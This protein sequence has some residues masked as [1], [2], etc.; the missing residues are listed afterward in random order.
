MAKRAGVLGALVWAISGLL[1]ALGAY[2]PLNWLL[3]RVPGFSYFR[4]PARWLVLYALGISLLAGVGW[5][6]LSELISARQSE[7]GWAN[8]GTELQRL[9]IRP[10]LF[11][12]IVVLLLVAWGFLS[13]LLIEYVPTGP[14]AL[15]EAPSML[16]V[17]GWALEICLLLVVLL[18]VFKSPWNGKIGR[19][20]LFLVAGAIVALF[21]AT[22]TLP[23]NNLT[24]PE[25]FFD[26]RPPISRILASTNGVPD[27]VLSLSDIFFD[28]GDQAELNTI[29][30]D[31]LTIAAQYDYTIAIK[32]KEIVAP[33]LSVIYGLSSVDGFD[34]GI[35]PLRS[36]SQLMKLILPKG[37]ET[38]DGRLRE[39]LDTIPDARWLDL[40]N[41]G[42]LITD[43]VGD[44]WQ[45]GVFFDRQHSVRLLEGESVSVGYLPEF[46]GTEL[47][48][49]ASDKPESVGLL[50]ADGQTWDIIPETMGQGLYRARFPAPALLQEV[51]VNSC[52]GMPACELH[53][54]TLFDERD[55]AFQS[56]VPG[57]YRMIHSSDVKIYENLD[58]L[59]RA[60]LVHDWWQV[61]DRKAAG[62][63]MLSPDFDFRTTAVV[64]AA[65]LPEAEH[66]I[67]D[68]T[69]SRVQ[70]MQYTPERIVLKT[71]GAQDGLLILTDANYPG[72]RAYID[73]QPVAIYEADGLFRGVYL[74]AGHHE[75]VFALESE[76][77]AVGKAVTIVALIMAAL[78][79]SFQL[80]VYK[81]RSL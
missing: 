52:A 28:P 78:L 13:R 26:I 10:L 65:E 17:L 21:A 71:Y 81:K 19:L 45:D 41:A 77:Y 69:E 46:E 2:N 7:N 66:D 32:Q 50:T 1:L 27:R 35:L 25:A 6:I 80:F 55:G 36:Y 64:V 44:I 74:S 67:N 60:F 40:F 22:R 76:S 31:Q 15:F 18:L 75:V 79:L 14:E 4:V 43:K 56:L 12:L 33:N 51:V 53:S 23:Y 30:G 3:V 73:G 59:P 37:A 16:T 20:A 62:L 11:F 57:D 47:R 42:F 8:K 9:I 70:T 63:M 54:L 24:T 5:Q 72:W 39:Y 49:L 38:T 29:Y 48:L 68:L 34:G 58:V 61:P